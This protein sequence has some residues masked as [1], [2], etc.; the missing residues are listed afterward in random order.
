MKTIESSKVAVLL[1]GYTAWAAANLFRGFSPA[2]IPLI[3]LFTLLGISLSTSMFPLI[4]ACS[5]IGLISP[6]LM[7]WAVLV[8]GL[9]AC[10]TGSAMKI[11]IT[12]FI[13]VAST[14]WLIPVSSSIPLIVI[15]A[16]SALIGKKHLRCF[17]IPAGFIISV[18]FTG[19]PGSLIT[20]PVIA[21]STIAAGALSY[22]IPEVNTSRQ[23]VLLPAPFEGTWVVWIAIEAGGVRDSIPMMAISLGED[24]LFLQ[25]GTDTLSFTMIPGDTLAITLVRKFK[26][27]NHSVIHAVAGGE[28][29]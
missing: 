10:A 16:A 27:F 25:S 22:D 21:G 19:L 23:E 3:V 13:A 12:G 28:R 11:R 8:S 1:A 9:L 7:P 15:A 14:L 5:L 6:V 18:F 26:P 4:F 2:S 20:E 17:L 29:L 24:M